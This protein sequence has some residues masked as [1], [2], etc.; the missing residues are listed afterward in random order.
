MAKARIKREQNVDAGTV[1]FTE[2]ATGDQLV[3]D[4]SVIYPMYPDF[5]DIQR[6]GVTHFINAKCGDSA[7]DP[8]TPAIPQI[9]AIWESLTVAKV[10]SQRGEGTGI[11]GITDTVTAV[12]RVLVA[13]GNKVEVEEVASAVATWK[14]LP[15][16]EDG[17]AKG[18]K[19]L[20]DEKTADDR[21]KLAKAEL[22]KERAAQRAKDLA[23]KAK[24]TTSDFT[25]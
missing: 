15:P 1:T 19:N 20:F 25:L 21:V 16:T 18:Y 14:E 4:A 23:K 13:L 6:H 2:L 10:W 17:E 12:H 9:K 3:C 8:L 22:R 5:D 24:A 7:S 11:G